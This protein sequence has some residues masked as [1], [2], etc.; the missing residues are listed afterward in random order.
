MFEAFNQRA[1]DVHARRGFALSTGATVAAYMV[2]GGVLLAFVRSRPVAD[3]EK[4]I[5]VTFEKALPKNALPPP[6]P[7]EKRQPAKR[8]RSLAPPPIKELVQPKEIPKEIPKESEAP[9]G[10]AM[11]ETGDPYGTT[12]GVPGGAVAPP[13]PAPAPP[14]APKPR[15]LEPISL[16]EEAIAPVPDPANPIP[17][18]PEAARAAGIEG[19]V[20]LKLVISE[21]GLVTSVQIMRGD[22]MLAEAAVKVVK[23]WRFTPAMLD[24]KP[25]AVFRILPLA[26]NSKVGGGG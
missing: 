6:P 17:G 15:K 16:P 21:T 24:G 19:K 22:P 3:D 8:V 12:G 23:Q 9:R 7:V 1:V 26:F 13:A 25:I 5:E 18:Y 14:P 4:Q 2:I 11:R 10:V 20:I